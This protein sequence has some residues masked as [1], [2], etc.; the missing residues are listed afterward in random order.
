MQAPHDEEHVRLY[1]S[2]MQPGGCVTK[3]F[4][5]FQFPERR[6][7]VRISYGAR[8]L[9]LNRLSEVRALNS[10][11]QKALRRADF[12]TAAR[13]FPAGPLFNDRKNGK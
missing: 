10:P 6:K 13:S 8:R 12:C 7:T 9:P 5:L 2:K 4:Q 1:A 11:L 3:K